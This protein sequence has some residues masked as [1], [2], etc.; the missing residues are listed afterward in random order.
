VSRVYA[1][2]QEGYRCFD[3]TLRF[4]PID[5]IAGVVINEGTQSVV[6][7]DETWS[8]RQ[9]SFQIETVDMDKAMSTNQEAR[10]NMAAV[11][12]NSEV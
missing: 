8:N 1:R 2:R 11:R 9:A 5:L 12:L 6:S 4:A 7:I 10:H 3:D